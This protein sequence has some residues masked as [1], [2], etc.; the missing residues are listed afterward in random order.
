[1][2]QVAI[3]IIAIWSGAV[4]GGVI[5]GLAVGGFVMAATSSAG[6]LMQARFFFESSYCSWMTMCFNMLYASQHR[7]L[8][9]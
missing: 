7:S 6:T 5:S 1:M 4:G 8:F 3:F 2:H 9:A